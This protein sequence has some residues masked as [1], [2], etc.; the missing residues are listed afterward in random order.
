MVIHRST[1]ALRIAKFLDFPWW[2]L[3]SFIIVPLPLRDLV[4]N[5]VAW[6]RYESFR[7]E[8]ERKRKR[9]GGVESEKSDTQLLLYYSSDIDFGERKKYVNFILNGNIASLLIQNQIIKISK[10]ENSC[11]STQ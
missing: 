10:L 5:L 9:K 1:A 7:R 4:Y 11:L 3:Y 6:S 2:L 8:K